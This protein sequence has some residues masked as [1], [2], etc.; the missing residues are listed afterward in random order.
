MAT[1]TPI[2]KAVDNAGSGA[3]VAGATAEV[4]L[5]A[6]PDR[7]YLAIFNI[8]DDVDTG[9]TL[10]FNLDGTAAIATVGS[11]PLLPG[12]SFIM[13]GAVVHTGV[14]SV[15]ATTIGHKYTVLEA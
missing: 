6:N 5:A 13:E 15:I 12:A 4:A 3:L 9:E 2:R 14:V 11:I 8:D 7:V 1:V 10:W